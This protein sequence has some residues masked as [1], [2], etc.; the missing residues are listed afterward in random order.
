MTEHFKPV[1]SQEAENS[2]KAYQEVRE[3]LQAFEDSDF[4]CKAFEDNLRRLP[5]YKKFGDNIPAEHMEK[6]RQTFP[7]TGA[8]KLG[9]EQF[10]REGNTIAFDE[11]KYS[12]DFVEKIKKYWACIRRQKNRDMRSSLA[13]SRED[14]VNDDME[15]SS[16]HNAAAEQLVT[17]GLAPRLIA[18]YLVALISESS[19]YGHADTKRDERVA[20][21]Y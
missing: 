6:I 9:L 21:Y 10:F 16:L 5:L 8:Y 17:D 15:R 1:P 18:R 20:N 3:F 7:D 2:P 11:S 12:H 4:Y 14:I 13:R 19:G